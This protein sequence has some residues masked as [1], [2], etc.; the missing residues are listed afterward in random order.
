MKMDTVESV[1]EHA[2]PQWFVEYDV[3]NQRIKL[4]LR[5]GTRT[6]SSNGFINLKA[7]AS[8]C[9]LTADDISFHEVFQSM[10][11]DIMQRFISNLKQAKDS[12]IVSDIVRESL[13]NCLRNMKE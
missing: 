6:Y 5:H 10:Y 2:L 1:F 3:I 9:D 11:I 12:A 4:T 13:L 8:E 7:L